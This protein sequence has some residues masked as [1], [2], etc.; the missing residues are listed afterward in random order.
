MATVAGMSVLAP[1]LR[2][3]VR[4]C[5][6]GLG[7]S[8]L[9]EG[10]LDETS[11]A[12]WGAARRAGARVVV[13]GSQDHP[14]GALRYV[15]APDSWSGAPLRRL[16]WA[17]SELV[18]PSLDAVE[19]RLEALG[20]DGVRRLRPPGLL[21]SGQGALR[22][23]Q[24]VGPAGEVLYLTE[25]SGEVPGFW[26][27]RSADAPT[28]LFALVAASVRLEATRSWLVELL[29]VPVASD[30][31]VAVGVL[32]DAFG[33]A[34]TCRHRISSLQLD[35]PSLI[36]VDQYPSAADPSGAPGASVA[37]AVMAT[38]VDAAA[39]EATAL[40]WWQMTGTLHRGPD[41]LLLQVAGV[42]GESGGRA[43]PV[44]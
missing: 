40:A 42:G 10:R 8:L 36:E 21:A 23:A 19:R 24:W 30:H 31:P 22:A 20:L 34:P 29:R 5:R 13:M 9:D 11:A 38:V 37:G 12:A 17:A 25:I 14:L 18:V 28:H 7:L 16:G 6:E 26:L 43:V 39:V 1:S 32:N 15:E 2:A 44:V 35:G 33:L 27:P 41:G 4:F 3:A